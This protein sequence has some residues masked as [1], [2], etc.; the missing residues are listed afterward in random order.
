MLTGHRSWSKHPEKNL[1]FLENESQD[2]TQDGVIAL[3]VGGIAVI[4]RIRMG[5][6]EGWVP[7]KQQWIEMFSI[8][9]SMNNI[10]KKHGHTMLYM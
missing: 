2:E 6:F 8:L 10:Q 9:Y 1:T 4:G 5:L 7:K 3:F